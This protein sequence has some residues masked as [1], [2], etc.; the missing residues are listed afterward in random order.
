M[1]DRNLMR[2]VCF[3][4]FG[5]PLTLLPLTTALRARF[6]AHAQAAVPTSPRETSWSTGAERVQF[7]HSRGSLTRPIRLV[8]TFS[9]PS[10]RSSRTAH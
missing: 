5:Q 6:T 2:R 3:S 4:A 8:R 1:T 10:F 9:A 7:Q